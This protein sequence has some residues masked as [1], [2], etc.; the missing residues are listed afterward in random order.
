MI[1]AIRPSFPYD[2]L[3]RKDAGVDPKCLHHWEGFGRVG[4][5]YVWLCINCHGA[6]SYVCTTDVPAPLDELQAPEI[7]P[8]DL[9]DGSGPR[10]PEVDPVDLPDP[11]ALDLPDR[12]CGD[13]PDIGR[14]DL[15]D[16][17]DVDLPDDGGR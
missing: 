10:I 3:S 4:D 17:P 14:E 5:R 6:R 13:L 9:P 16:P 7:P 2:P 15:P 11:A 12:G 8:V 1:R